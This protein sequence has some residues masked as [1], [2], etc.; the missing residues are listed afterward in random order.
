VG[1]LPVLVAIG[2]QAGIEKERVITF[3]DGT[4]GIEEVRRAEQIALQAEISGVPTFALDGEPLFSGALAPDVMA[5]R[6]SN[7]LAAR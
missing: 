2:T 6:L 3:L 4:A 7:A 1:E 5:A